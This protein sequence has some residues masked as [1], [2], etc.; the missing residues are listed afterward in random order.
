MRALRSLSALLVLAAAAGFAAQGS[1]PW[2]RLQVATP[3]VVSNAFAE[4]MDTLRAGETVA[5][6]FA[7]QR[8]LGLSLTDFHTQLAIDPRK[9]RSGLV[10]TFRRAL[11]DSAPSRIVVRASP[12]RRLW[13][14]RDLHGWDAQT[15][16]IQWKPEVIRVEGDINESV[17]QAL[18]A[19][20]PDTVLNAEERTRLAWDLADVYAWQVDF[21]R[22][23]QP[24]DHYQILLERRVSEEGDVRFGRILASDLRVSGKSLSAFRF[25]DEAGRSAFYA[26]EGLSLRRAFLRAPVQFRRVSST[27]SRARLHPVLGI[28][29]RHEGTDYAADAGTPV[30][31][32]GDGIVARAGWA[33]GYGNMVELRHR[34]G[35]VTRYAHLRRFAPGV[36]PGAQVEQG[37]TI[38]YVGSTGLAT[39]PHLHYEFRVNDV[40]R[41]ARRVDLAGGYPISSASAAAFQKERER[42]EALLY[43]PTTQLLARSE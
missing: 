11:T 15:E 17:Y 37:Q 33:G 13:L 29:R 20:V 6:V 12:D 18:D 27:F 24:G 1:W 39:G 31:A 23:I 14:Q 16:A 36:R 21:T 22:D 8:V 41:D 30:M 5:D 32:A 42:L 9:I 3:I 28:T 40:A 26:A 10:F 25:E 34:N 19:D 2:R 43:R 7:R 4:T 38:A 35:I